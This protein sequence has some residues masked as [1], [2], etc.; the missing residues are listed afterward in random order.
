MRTNLIKTVICA[1]AATISLQA[2]AQITESPGWSSASTLTNPLETRFA[3]VETR[4]SSPAPESFSIV[5]ALMEAHRSPA[6]L[7]D[8]AYHAALQPDIPLLSPRKGSLASTADLAGKWINHYK[9]ANSY[10]YW[11][12]TTAEIVPVAG[13][14]SLVTINNFWHDNYKVTAR[15][16]LADGTLRIASQVVTTR[17][18]GT[19]LSVAVLNPATGLP[20]RSVDLV[21]YIGADGNITI[22]GYWGIF[23][24]KYDPS[25]NEAYSK[26]DY[27][28]I[29][30]LTTFKRGTS[31]M[32]H[33]NA[34][35]DKSFS[36]PVI[37]TQTGKNVLTVE[38]FLGYGQT[39][40][41]LLN[42]DK[43]YTSNNQIALMEYSTAYTF[44]GN[45]KYDDNGNVTSFDKVFSFPA[46][47][48]SKL[49]E[50]SNVSCTYGKSYWIGRINDVKLE[51]NEPVNW[52]EAFTNKFEGEGTAASPWLIKTYNDVAQFAEMINSD[53]DMSYFYTASNSTTGN[54]DT[55]YYARPFLGKYFRVEND[56]DMTGYSYTPAGED[57]SHWFAGTLDGNGHT[58]KGFTI[59]NGT[60]GHAAFIGRLD[61]DG[62]IRNLTLE[63]IS[64]TGSS[65]YV[66]GFVSRSEGILEGLTLRN[67]KI[68][69][70]SGYQGAG[71][72][73]GYTFGAKNCNVE[74]CEIFAG[75][76]YGGG[77]AGQNFYDPLVNCHI[78]GTEI[79]G[80]FYNAPQTP[81]AGL[82]GTSTGSIQD[83]SVAA[84]IHVPFSYYPALMGGLVGEMK[85]LGR[86]SMERSFFT[87]RIEGSTGSYGYLNFA[88][89]LA[90]VIC[91]DVTDC[92]TSATIAN[93]KSQYIGGLFGL[94]QYVEDSETQI[95][96][97]PKFTR[98]YSSSYLIA[99]ANG[100][101][102]GA[103]TCMEL[104]GS[105]NPDKP[106]TISDCWFN[107]DI[108]D[109]GS[110]KY[111][112][113]TSQLTSA[114]GPQGFSGQSAWKFESNYYP[115]L[116]GQLAQPGAD[117]SA[118]SM[119][120]GADNNINLVAADVTLNP[121]GAT[122]FSF[123]NN[124]EYTDK[125]KF[126]TISGNTL[127]INR[128]NM[129]GYDTIVAR[130]GVNEK[131][132]VA[133]I[134]PISFEGKGTADNPWL[135][136]NKA[137]M[138][139]LYSMTS[140]CK[141]SF[142]GTYYKMTADID[143]EYD[144][145]FNGISSTNTAM[146]PFH[147]T[148]DGD[149]H[150]FHRLAIGKL[151]WKVRPEDDPAGKGTVNTDESKATYIGLFGVIGTD[152][153]VK[154][155]NI[156]ADCRYE[157][158]ASAGAIAGYNYGVIENCRNYA[159]I[160]GQSSWI[161][162][163][164]GQNQKGSTTRRC[165]NAG[166]VT[167]GWRNVG[168][169]SGCAY[170]DIEE[171][172]NTGTV[173]AISLY[174]TSSVQYAGGIAGWINGG[175]V[176]N[177]ANY[178]DVYSLQGYAGGITGML[179]S[180]TAG[181]KTNDINSSLT[182]GAVTS[183]APKL[184][185]GIA[186][187]VGTA[188]TIAS[189]YYD[190]Q[191]VP[192]GALGCEPHSGMNGKH[193]SDL[194]TGVALA[195][196]STDKWDFT[197][198]M[199]PALSL[200]KD[201]VKVAAAR[202]IYVLFKD[203]EN[204]LD[205]QNDA[206]LS[207]ADGLT[208]S[209]TADNGFSIAGN[210]LK[211]PT[212]P[213][214]VLNDVLTAS[215]NG[216]VRNIP[217]MMIPNAPWD[218]EGTAQSPWLIQ[219]VQDWNSLGKLQASTLNT[220]QDKYFRVTADLDFSNSEFVCL[221]QD[222]VVFAGTLDGANHTIK[223]FADSTTVAYHGPIGIVSASGTIKNITFDGSVHCNLAT[224]SYNYL[225][226][227]VGKLYGTLDNVV[228]KSTVTTANK[229]YAAGVAAFV[230]TGAKLIDVINKGK[231]AAY[232]GYNA[233]LSVNVE[234]GVTFTRCG[235]EGELVAGNGTAA[236]IGGLVYTAY[237]STFD[238]CYNSANLSG[239]GNTIGGLIANCQGAN[240]E[241]RHFVMKGCWNSGN[242]TG[243]GSLGGL[244]AAANTSVGGAIVDMDSCYNT[245][246]I[247]CDYTY[248]FSAVAGLIA[249]YKPGSTIT[250]C[251]NSGLIQGIGTGA[252][253]GVGGIIGTAAGVPT[254]AYPVNVENC[255]NT[256]T[257]DFSKAGYWVG[258]IFGNINAHTYLDGCYNTGTIKANYGAGGISG[259]IYGGSG[260]TNQSP[261]VENC[262][263]TGEVVVNTRF[264][265][266][267][268]GCAGTASS[269]TGYCFTISK[270]W[271]SGRIHSLATQ[272][273]T[274][275]TST[276]VDGH[277]IG[278]IAG[279]GISTYSTCANFGEVSGPT[280]VGGIVGEPMM[281]ANQKR[282]CVEM[283]YNAGNVYSTAEGGVCAG[284]VPTTD[285][286]FWGGTNYVDY[287]YYV[288]DFGN[289]ST[290]HAGTAVT[291]AQLA[292]LNIGGNWT[293]GH[294]FI[295]PIPTT[296]LKDD[297]W[298]TMAAALVPTGNDTYSRITTTFNVGLP[299]GVEWSVVTPGVPLEFKG[300]AGRWK[301]KF[302][303][304]V[305]VAAKK[306]GF[307]K[308]V[309]FMAQE[310]NCIGSL[311]AGEIVS[312]RFFTLDGFETS[313]PEAKN[314]KVYLVITTYADGR[315]ETSKIFN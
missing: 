52:P 72:I 220:Y 34:T 303:G 18:D 252:V 169:I 256:G 219:T 108:T 78:T 153:V 140:V 173:K 45:F 23:Y 33:Y 287:S 101:V 55:I 159:D 180:S 210:T 203:N 257:L 294:D 198:G 122:V 170:T 26:D 290:Q 235:N 207:Q 231:V 90:G 100:Y 68:W 46:S 168:G 76:G 85:G 86:I 15:V 124:G 215:F 133:M 147:G 279:Q 205:I 111:G 258:G 71:G 160:T 93:P 14:D 43:T 96:T 165:Y 56:I 21:A 50:T 120:F 202:K 196:L 267:I 233:G 265:G 298:N 51:L 190:D 230:Y 227:I 306:G 131:Y 195:G 222:P 74:N 188:G 199:Y 299:E 217:L 238:H 64:V 54:L 304:E 240:T 264:A 315:T 118:S 245:G 191:L 213:K 268:I 20:M 239:Q 221:A 114:E 73:A 193:T 237:P 204:D 234:A 242:L 44:S 251:W 32:S 3:T 166:N 206:T 126:A 301:G 185:G 281:K 11:G 128:E 35:T 4:K 262:W 145:T 289:A 36:Y 53:N 103:N 179:T 59:N 309:S 274:T 276:S 63:N 291:V 99:G 181:D 275:T 228:N 311:E 112:A 58:I 266:G 95:V 106:A 232:T 28:N 97:Q 87:G 253:Y 69:C 302:T 280:F 30:Y 154:N 282:T 1:A 29:Y 57:G 307:V 110:L 9:F 248:S 66:G 132:Y 146:T 241:S 139:A 187:G 236:Y 182:I 208:W 89:G 82:A 104:F 249:N 67:S 70:N 197:Q 25:E 38:N 5:E 163:I 41:L 121:M 83:C 98:S 6:K 13:N 152:G 148:F 288:T 107:K 176:T 22:P 271:N 284:I 19:P 178:G 127:K 285:A 16:N 143:M 7:S 115:R 42:R 314:G 296:A 216:M 223:N 162:G 157:T 167:T 183:D 40:E 224:G 254:A 260:I 142:P 49:I 172:V 259:A 31:T 244:I 75:D 200:F 243:R 305:V 161:G 184:V 125:G 141:F 130:N 229:S 246:T 278:G 269:S 84:Y 201:E 117:L 192:Q 48:D 136:K 177:C 286:T 77:I 211:V 247:T 292:N 189:N 109:L 272:A 119:I 149:G 175:S 261:Y 137:D 151:V 293:A 134:A 174:N 65:I 102:P 60:N 150:T 24:D 10:I 283:C 158:F 91:A 209:V 105:M 310:T 171:C 186:G 12:G 225:G 79:Y 212:A 92:Y 47:S 116:A 295:F 155:V 62:A 144:E 2:G 37:V 270:C 129:F 164:V 17:T 273:G 312:Q 214:G 135:I 123:L 226:G 39:V 300:N 194:I 81:L 255:Y 27:V 8:E 156:A 218:G 138:M 297:G 308:N 250:N 277:G 263:N 80:M 88:G 61:M 113:T 94:V 313:R